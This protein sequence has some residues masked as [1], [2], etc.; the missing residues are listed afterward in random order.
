MTAKL[1]K[2]LL[3]ITIFGIGC[4]L[5]PAQLREQCTALGAN[6]RVC[7]EG[8]ECY[9]GSASPVGICLPEQNGAASE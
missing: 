3:L 6:P 1:S 7:D 5:P 2:S 9:V 4:G 8:L